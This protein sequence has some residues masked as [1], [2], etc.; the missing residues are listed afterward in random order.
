MKYLKHF[1]VFLLVKLPLQLVG[2][3]LLALYLP[4]HNRLR[5]VVT[6]E[7]GN[8]V[9]KSANES[10]PKVLRWFDNHTIYLNNGVYDATSVD[11]LSGGYEYRKWAKNPEG[12]LARYLWLAWRNPV[13]YFQTFVL[14]YAPS[15]N[16]KHYKE[17]RFPAVPPYND[18]YIELDNG[19]WER[20]Y[21]KPIKWLKKF[22]LRLRIGYKL[23]HDDGLSQI[24]SNSPAQWVFSI[25]IRRSV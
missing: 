1:I 4:F 24:N 21:F 17:S 8:I 14:G 3:V 13:N 22:A 7:Q 15:K 9:D 16:C 20:S 18:Y 25:G 12:F 10:L 19:V 11:G 2:T 6:D 5:P 23:K